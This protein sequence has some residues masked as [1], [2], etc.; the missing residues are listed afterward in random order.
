MSSELF[1]NRI[2]NQVWAALVS[3]GEVVELRVEEDSRD[4]ARVGQ[5]YKA[6]V[7]NIVPDELAGLAHVEVHA[8]NLGGTLLGLATEDTVWIDND[9]AGYGWRG[10]RGVDL[11]S[12]VTHEFGHVLGF[13]HDYHDSVMASKLRPGE[14]RMGRSPILFDTL[15]KETVAEADEFSA[16]DEVFAILSMD[17][18]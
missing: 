18:F 17:G 13:D 14:S 5:I 10:S 2:G 11:S 3:E 16:I 12:V 15:R 7:C 1:L 9:A 6:R 8:G 4:R